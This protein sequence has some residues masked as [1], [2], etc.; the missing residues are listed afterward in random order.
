VW[1][2]ADR[3]LKDEYQVGA[4]A[5]SLDT[6]GRVRRTEHFRDRDQFSFLECFDIKFVAD[7]L[8]PVA[9]ISIGLVFERLPQVSEIQRQ[10]YVFPPGILKRHK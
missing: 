8:Y 6:R 3:E 9:W 5:Y 7:L 10:G 1:F 4:A 2:A